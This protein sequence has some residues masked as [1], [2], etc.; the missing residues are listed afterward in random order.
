MPQFYLATREGL[1]EAIRLA[2][3]ALELDPRFYPAAVQAGIGHMQNAIWGYADDPQ[4][5]RREAVRLLR[6]ALSIDDGDPDTLAHAAAIS[7]FMV[8]DSEREIEMADRAVALNPNSFLAWNSRG[9]VY[10]IVG[11]PEEAIRSFERAIRMSP[12]DLRLYLTLGGMAQA[13]IELGRFDEAIVAAKKAQRL[14]PAFQ[15]PYR[16]L[17]SAFAHLGRDAEAREA[18]AHLLEV[19]PGFTISAWIAR[20]GQSNSKLTI[21]GLRKAGLPE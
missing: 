10:R 7:A 19:D 20:G 5:D 8:G 2:H 1:A 13:F 17:A 12:V 15:V 3:R 6:L 14:N 11:L 4:F 9:H 21:E 16:C 18:A